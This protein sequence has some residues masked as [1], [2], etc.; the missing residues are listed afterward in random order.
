MTEIPTQITAA[1]RRDVWGVLG[2]PPSQVHE[3]SLHPSKGL[4]A[5]L[6]VLDREG[7]PITHGGDH[8]TTTVRIPL[9]QEV[10]PA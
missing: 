3:I 7:R 2:L 8:L 10:S 1:Q 5:S 6:Y 9:A 4:Q